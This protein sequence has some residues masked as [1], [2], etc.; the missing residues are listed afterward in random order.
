LGFSGDPFVPVG[1][2]FEPVLRRASLIGREQANDG[3]TASASP[4]DGGFG[5]KV[6]GLADAEF[7]L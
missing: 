1:G 4:I 7:M 5:R 6:N 2:V 3:I